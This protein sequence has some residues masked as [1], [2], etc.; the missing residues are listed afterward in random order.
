M[1]PLPKSILQHFAKSRRRALLRSAAAMSRL[2]LG[3]GQ[4]NP[5]VRWYAGHGNVFDSAPAIPILAAGMGTLVETIRSIVI[6]AKTQRLGTHDSS[7]PATGLASDDDNNR[8]EF[9]GH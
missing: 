8:A 7:S 2:P 1:K 3:E 6:R 4:D 9:I 5:Q